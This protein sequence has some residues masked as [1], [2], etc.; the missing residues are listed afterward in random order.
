MLGCS[1]RRWAGKVNTKEL[2]SEVKAFP[3]PCPGEESIILG[4][5]LITIVILKMVRLLSAVMLYEMCIEVKQTSLVS[6]RK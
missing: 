3:S 5:L 4:V 2:H 1:G 6:S